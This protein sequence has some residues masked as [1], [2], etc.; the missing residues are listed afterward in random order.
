MGICTRCASPLGRPCPVSSRT[1]V[2]QIRSL[3]PGYSIERHQ[4]ST[5]MLCGGGPSVS[6]TWTTVDSG[7]S[8]RR[9]KASFCTL[10]SSALQVPQRVLGVQLWCPLSGWHLSFKG[11][12]VVSEREFRG[13]PVSVQPATRRVRRTRAHSPFEVR[14]STPAI[15]GVPRENRGQRSRH[16]GYFGS[17]CLSAVYAQT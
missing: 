8:K 9:T 11:T 2:Y 4:L 13:L 7:Q 16:G 15:R 6:F 17:V 10:N 12:P 14:M 5:L 3:S 1:G